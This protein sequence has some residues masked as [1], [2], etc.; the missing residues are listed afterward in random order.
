MIL[1]DPNQENNIFK[2]YVMS[3]HSHFHSVNDKSDLKLFSKPN[4]LALV[5]K[6]K[7]R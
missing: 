7:V 5:L 1:K 4:P 2:S 6:K 3:F